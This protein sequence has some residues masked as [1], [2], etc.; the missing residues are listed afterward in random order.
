[1]RESVTSR[2]QRAHVLVSGRV[3]GVS[4]R[5]YTQRKAH[6]FGLTGWVSNLW[7]GRVEAVFE[8]EIEA[9]RKMVSWCRSGPPS[10]QVDDV[11][12]E[13]KA[14]TGEFGGFHI[15]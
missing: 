13:Y 8:G 11:Q 2:P 5:W 7:D 10:A 9:V 14:S 1:V 3:Q 15:R 6:D 12:V 4:F